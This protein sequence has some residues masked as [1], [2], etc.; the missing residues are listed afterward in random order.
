MIALD[1]VELR[2]NGAPVLRSFD[3][4]VGRALEECDAVLATQIRGRP[5]VWRIAPRNKIGAVTVSVPHAGKSVSILIK[6]KLEISRLFFLLDYLVNPTGWRDDEVEVTEHPDFVPA[7]AHLFERQVERALRSGLLRGYRGR[8]ENA[9]VVRGR[10]DVGDQM[11]CRFGLPVPIAVEYEEYTADIPENRI[12]R[13]A[14]ERMLRRLPDT[15]AGIRAR[16]LRQRN[17]LVQEQVTPPA[18]DEKPFWTATR[19]NSRY[20]P[21]LRLAEIIMRDASVEQ[22]V[23]DVRID[24]FLFS[25]WKIFEDFVTVA[26][27]RCL[28]EAAGSVSLQAEHYLDAAAKV[29]MKPDLVWYDESGRPL[30]VVDAKYKAEERNGFPDRICIRSLPTARCSACPRATSSTRRALLPVRNTSSAA[31]RVFA[32]ISTPW[33]WSSR[34]R[35]S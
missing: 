11:R 2:E 13:G 31:L 16:L 12:V 1:P 9:T 22:D 17:R 24:G 33:I 32:S 27:S 4:D 34:P 26:L 35:S 8:R 28:V 21:A 15:S 25:M 14:V 23:G 19:L 7:V 3:E 20:V 6:P 5:G 10:I 29:L 30:T 18:A